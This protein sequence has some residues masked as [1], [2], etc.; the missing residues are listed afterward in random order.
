MSWQIETAFLD[1]DGT[2]N[3]D[4]PTGG[5]N[6]TWDDITFLPRAKEAIRSDRD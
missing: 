1:R 3:A 2:I 4:H 6:A 5:Y